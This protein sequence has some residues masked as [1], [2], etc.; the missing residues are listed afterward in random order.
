MSARDARRSSLEGGAENDY[1]KLYRSRLRELVELTRPSFQSSRNNNNNDSNNNDND[2]NNNDDNDSDNNGSNNGSD[3]DGTQSA[4]RVKKS[5]RASMQ[6]Q[7]TPL[8]VVYVQTMIAPL[9]RLYA[10]GVPTS[11]GLFTP[12]VSHWLHGPYRLSSMNR[13]LNAKI[14]W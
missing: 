10:W 11:V 8:S 7:L 6:L 5:S 2:N 9:R 4:A 13:V 1:L 3:D 14:T 12:R